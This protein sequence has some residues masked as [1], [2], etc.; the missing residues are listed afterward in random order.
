MD[1][2]SKMDVA[3]WRDSPLP[4]IPRAGA[5]RYFLPPTVIGIAGTLLLHS[6]LIQFVSFVSRGHKPKPP[7]AQES[8]NAPSKSAQDAD[9][10]VLIS[11]PTIANATQAGSESATSSLPD[12]SKMKIKSPISVDPPAFLNLETLAL[13]EDPAS[14][15]AAGGADGGELSRSFGIYT[16][17]IQAR[18]DRVWRRPRTPVNESASGQKATD[19]SFQ[20]VAQ[21]VQDL[22]GNVQE[23]MLPRCNGSPAWRN[24]LVLAIQHA[25][26]LPAPPSQTV[27]STSISLTFVGLNYFVGAPDDDYEP[28]R[29]A[30]TSAQ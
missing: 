18:I 7:E 3:D 15:Q 28:E 25:S 19:D 17:Q 4:I 13:S 29:R 22:K 30:L 14:L 20:C 27:F 11:L 26:P 2:G 24:S 12:L 9:N 23:V 21:I 16:G 10:L 6:M 1:T 8:A 5:R